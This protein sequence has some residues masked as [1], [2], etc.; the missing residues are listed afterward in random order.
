MEGFAALVAALGALL[1]ATSL[2]QWSR[3]A[4]LRAT[5][6]KNL[7]LAQSLPAGTVGRASL[8]AAA[9]SAAVELAVIT[10]EP[11][12]GR[13]WVLQAGVLGFLLSAFG[14]LNMPVDSTPE[15]VTGREAWAYYIGGLV[16]IALAT[17][18]VVRVLINR[19]E[20]RLLILRR[21]PDAL[22]PPEGDHVQAPASRR[23]KVWRFIAEMSG[24]PD[25][26]RPDSAHPAAI[27]AAPV[28]DVT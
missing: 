5:I 27:P 8:E 13:A 24:E 10:F 26:V 12:R 11:L 7:A 25:W 1:G 20:R 3:P 17:L 19:R 9:D 22:L 18:P 28:T 23:R 6:E 16:L 15:P 4:R 21:A 14:I 2:S